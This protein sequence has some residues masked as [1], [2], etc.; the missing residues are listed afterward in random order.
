MLLSSLYLELETQY[1][2]Q[3]YVGIK[4]DCVNNYVYIK[5]YEVKFETKGK[6]GAAVVEVTLQPVTVNHIL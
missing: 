4:F 1:S 3:N 6:T 5:K 2:G